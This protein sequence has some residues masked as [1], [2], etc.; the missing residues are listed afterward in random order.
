MAPLFLILSVRVLMNCFVL[1]MPYAS[2]TKVSWPQKNWAMVDP[3]AMAGVSEKTVA[4]ATALFCQGMLKTGFLAL[5]CLLKAAGPYLVVP[6][7][8]F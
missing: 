8:V 1:L 2:H 3:S 5:K 7:K 4:V 6:L